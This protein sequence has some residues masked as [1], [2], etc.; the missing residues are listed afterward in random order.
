MRKRMRMYGKNEADFWMLSMPVLDGLVLPRK[1]KQL[2][3]MVPVLMFTAGDRR[4]RKWG[5]GKEARSEKGKGKEK[6]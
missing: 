6:E 5:K 3:P 2:V 4:G 1:S